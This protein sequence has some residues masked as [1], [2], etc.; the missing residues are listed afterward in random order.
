MSVA[1]PAFPGS[2]VFGT[3][4]IVKRRLVLFVLLPLAAIVLFVV[5]WWGIGRLGAPGRA[6]R[7]FHLAEAPA[8]PP[9]ER[10]SIRIAAFNIAHGRGGGASNWSDDLERGRRI[11]AIGAM[12]RVLDLDVAV[13]N[14]VDFDSS[15]SGGGDQA[16]A[17]AAVAGLPYVVEQASFD[18]SV[19]F[20]RARFGN[21][22]LS[23]HPI[24][25]A[26]MVNLPGHSGLEAFLAGKKRG[27]LVRVT[28][29]DGDPFRVLALHLE[30]REE[31][32]RLASVQVIP[33]L[34]A[35]DAAPLFVA[36]DLNTGFEN[37]SLTWLR[38]KGLFGF[39]AS[40]APTFP[41]DAPRK[42]IDWILC[43][44]AR[45]FVEYRVV[46]TDLSDHCPV[47]AEIG[48]ER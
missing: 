45:A 1:G 7:M 25:E 12:L 8:L 35:E 38:G 33:G 39:R 13:L 41:A 4:R 3:L 29:V 22:V 44:A 47:V 40:G 16:H 11:G 24:A 19:P 18:V 5:V 34:V 20:F 26:R 37:D 42:E 36:G 14:E 15:W 6:V 9:A 46:P 32:T 48:G 43:P 30:P 21:A 27:L 31:P 23:R 2:G 17:I 28:P 10:G